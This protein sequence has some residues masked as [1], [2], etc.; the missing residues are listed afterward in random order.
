ML[1]KII[2]V[3]AGLGAIASLFMGWLPQ[4]VAIAL[5]VNAL[6]IFGIRMAI[7]AQD[8]ILGGSSIW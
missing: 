2:A 3:V 7:P 4:G 8:P 1:T 5:L 6:G